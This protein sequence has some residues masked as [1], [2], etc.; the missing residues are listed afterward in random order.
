MVTR[1]LFM[2]ASLF[3]RSLR[4]TTTQGIE[5]DHCHSADVET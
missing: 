1:S 3:A 5:Q 2:V 4:T